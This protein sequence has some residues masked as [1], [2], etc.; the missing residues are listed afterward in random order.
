MVRKRDFL[1]TAAGAVGAAFAVPASS[2]MHQES[3][4]PLRAPFLKALADATGGDM[5]EIQSTT[6]LRATL[7]R[8]LNEYRQ[9]YLIAYSPTG[10]ESAGW[11]AIKVSV[12][13]RGATVKTRQGY[14]R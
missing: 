11:H 8:L 4:G 1:K 6:E 12:S 5:V 10:V 3:A 13:K 9:R 2:E 14:E 7:L